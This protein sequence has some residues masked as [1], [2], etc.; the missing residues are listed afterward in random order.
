MASRTAGHLVYGRAWLSTIVAALK[1][2]PGAALLAAG[3]VRL[4]KVVGFN[5]QSSM[6]IA[7]LTPDECD[8]VGYPAGGLALTPSAEVNVTQATIG[9]I[10][11]ATFICTDSAAP[12]PNSCTG[13][14]IDDGVNV[15]VAEAF[16]PGQTVVF[17]QNGDYLDLQIAVAFALA[18]SL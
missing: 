9:V 16:V 14:W 1:T 2:V 12:G 6:T 7:T 15:V 3:K 8:F 4:T 13:Y 11:N 10:G 5:P 18:L 17:A